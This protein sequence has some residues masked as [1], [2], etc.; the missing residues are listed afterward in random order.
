MAHWIRVIGMS[1]KTSINS[2]SKMPI[3]VCERCFS[4]LDQRRRYVESIVGQYPDADH[5]NVFT[6]K[7]I[8]EIVFSIAVSE[9]LDD[10]D[11]Q[12]QLDELESKKKK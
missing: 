12:E 4:W 2:N 3:P 5:N 7:D 9:A 6:G 10:P 1:W 8:D 11:M